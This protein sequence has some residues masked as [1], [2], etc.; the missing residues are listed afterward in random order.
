MAGVDK[1][2]LDRPILVEGKYDKIKLESLFSGCILTT[3]GFSVFH[4]K[5]QLVMLRRMAREKGLLVLTDADGGGKQI[6][7]FLKGALPPDRVTNLY[8]PR[9]E[10]KEKRKEHRS[11]AGLL[12]VEGMEADVL[13]RL[14]APYTLGAEKSQAGEVLTKARLYADGYSGTADA[15]AR[16]GR[17]LAALEL[18]E[19]LSANA[20]I[21]VVNAL[22]GLPVYVAATEKI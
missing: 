17:L 4:R 16:R 6:R 5:E 21:E 9:V 7:A 11:K 19:D 18:P 22:G 10:G 8:I 13:R 12:G 1:P 15:T 20:L 3:G 14:L 2:T